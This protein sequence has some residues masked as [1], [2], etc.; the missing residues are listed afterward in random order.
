MHLVDDQDDVAALLDFADQA[1]H[2]AF[3]LATELGSRHKR[4]QI[5]EENLLVPELVGNVA[6]RNPLSQTLGNG[7]F[8][9]AGL[10]DE[11]GVVLLPAVENLNHPLGFHVSADDLVKLPGSGS[12][13]QIHAIAVQEL[14]LLIFLFGFFLLGRLLGSCRPLGLGGRI[15]ISAEKLV[16]QRKGCGLAVDFVIVSVRAVVPLTEHAAHLIGQHVQVFLGNAHLLHRLVDLRNAQTPGAFEAI[17]LIQGHA[18]LYLRNEHNG[19]IFLT[20]AAHFRLHSHSLLF[21]RNISFSQKYST[22]LS[23]KE[24]QIMNVPKPYFVQ[25]LPASNRV[26]PSSYHRW[27]MYRPPGGTVGPAAVRFPDF[28]IAP[29]SSGRIFPS[30]A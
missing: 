8:A 11:T 16:Q 26:T 28:R 7:G 21:S 3:K 30:A 23:K 29:I 6:L 2:P 19:D 18:V 10:A 24:K 20:L 17:A 9:H 12:A 22:D 25:S 13:G 14:M 4:R 1:L 15:G 27:V 5:Q